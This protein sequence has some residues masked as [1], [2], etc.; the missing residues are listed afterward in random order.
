MHNSNKTEVCNRI[1]MLF[2]IAALIGLIT[3]V[4]TFVSGSGSSMSF[5]N[6]V[7]TEVVLVGIGAGLRG[8][9]V[10]RKKQPKA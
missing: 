7:I 6:W 3:Y 1:S 8:L 4:S 10:M 2:F 5:G 9:G